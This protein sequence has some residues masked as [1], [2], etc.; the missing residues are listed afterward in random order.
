MKFIL[1]KEK[2]F[3][4]IYLEIFCLDDFFIDV[5]SGPMSGKKKDRIEIDFG[6]EWSVGP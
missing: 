6:K 3:S 4:H 5:K 1:K 2:K